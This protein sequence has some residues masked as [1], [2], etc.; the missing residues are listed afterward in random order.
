MT[1][2][3]PQPRLRVAE[4][5]EKEIEALIPNKGLK[6]GDR[7]PSE[8]TLAQTMNASRAS[9]REAIRQLVARQIIEVRKTGIFVAQPLPQTWAEEAIG[10][11]LSALVAEHVGY[12]HDVME[13]RT[14]LEGTAA[15]YAA[16]RADDTARRRIRER[17][18]EMEATYGNGDAREQARRD[19]AFHLAIAE[20]SN[21]AI[22]RHVM[23]SLLGLL[24]NSISQSLEKLYLLPRMAEGLAQQHRALYDAIVAGDAEAARGASD[25]HLTFIENSIRQIDDD[26]ARKDR[27]RAARAAH[28]TSRS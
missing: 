17:L 12:G 8:R 27:A 5:L 24:Q 14:A 3:E 9:L 1:T 26:L 21:N 25:T 13:V 22:L 16:L 20:A 18:E 4:R 7:L 28:I 19:A 11:P 10:T 6:P 23:S 15:Y 2:A